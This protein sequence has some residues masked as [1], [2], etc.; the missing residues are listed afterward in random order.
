M[1]YSVILIMDNETDK[2]I[3]CREWEKL[4]HSAWSRI[5]S[6]N[7]WHHSPEKSW[8]GKR[9]EFKSQKGWRKSIRSFKPTWTK[10]SL[11]NRDS[12]RMLRTCTDVH[13]VLCAYIM[14]SNLEGFVCWFV[15]F[16]RDPSWIFKQVCLFLGLFSSYWFDLSKFTMKVLLLSYFILLYFFK[17][18]DEGKPIQ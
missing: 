18:M 9:T 8:K 5:S 14:A 12:L 17:W 3:L 13:L 6:S 1:G 10:L 2:Q 4:E 11:N 15:C 16:L 7:S